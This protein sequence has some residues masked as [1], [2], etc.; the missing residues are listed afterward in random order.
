MVEVGA[1]GRLGISDQRK[2]R[3]HPCNSN[4]TGSHRTSLSAPNDSVV[5]HCSQS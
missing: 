1:K 5:W 4:M 2:Q 3:E